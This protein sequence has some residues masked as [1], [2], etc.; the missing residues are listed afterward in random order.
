MDEI[1]LA[2]YDVTC[3]TVGCWNE[4]ISRRVPAAAENPDVQ[5]GPCGAQLHATPVTE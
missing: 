4:G 2:Q 5:C 1:E 3:T